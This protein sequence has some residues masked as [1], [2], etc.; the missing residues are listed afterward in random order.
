MLLLFCIHFNRCL[1]W[2][3]KY[4][5]ILY[6]KI[7][8]YS[9]QELSAKLTAEIRFKAQKHDKEGKNP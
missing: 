7:C 3:V 5:L 8:C 6:V 2:L 9:E 4:Q 1:F